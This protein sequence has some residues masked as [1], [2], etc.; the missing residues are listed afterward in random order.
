M[1]IGSIPDH[2]AAKW[3]SLLVGGI[4]PVVVLLVS[5]DARDFVADAYNAK[6]P[7]AVL[8]GV[9][10]IL[11]IWI[12]L[13][14]GRGEARVIVSNDDLI[15][16]L[17]AIVDDAAESLLCVGSRGRDHEYFRAIEDRLQAKRQLRHT[18]VLWGAP[19]HE[20]MKKHLVS[21]AKKVTEKGRV[22]VAL[23]DPATTDEPE[24]SI[25]ANERRAVIVVAAVGEF[26]RYD[27]GILVSNKRDVKAVIQY[28]EALY[29]HATPL[30]SAKVKALPTT[31]TQGVDPSED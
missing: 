8:S 19:H 30:T 14:R 20:V 26:G 22:R 16:E 3:L 5:E 10:I 23:L 24:Q 18:R 29:D 6:W 9:A 4:V 21:V 31:Q 27:S 17:R 1:S 25:C 2:P 12:W 11:A 7:F 13:V 15:H 28:V